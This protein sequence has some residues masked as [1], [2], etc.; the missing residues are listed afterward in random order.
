MKRLCAFALAALALA[1]AAAAQNKALDFKLVNKTG[2]DINAVYIAPSDS[3]DWG[4][5]VMGKDTLDDGDSVE[6][7]FHPKANAKLW[8]LRVEDGDGNSVE[9]E[10]L[11]LTK[12]A[13][14]TLKIV[15]G[16]PTAEWK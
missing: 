8:D 10:R 2:V 13:E 12:I 16:K 6:I 4:D 7:E 3:D 14:L 5:D 9:W 11:D 15:K 1:W